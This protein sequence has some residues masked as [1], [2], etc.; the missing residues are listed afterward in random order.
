MGS[1]KTVEVLESSESESPSEQLDYTMLIL[2]L[3]AEQG[4]GSRGLALKTGI[5]KSPDTFDRPY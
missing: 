1:I 4:I 2:R 3:M 5:G